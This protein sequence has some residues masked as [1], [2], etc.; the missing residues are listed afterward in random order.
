MLHCVF[1]ESRQGHFAGKDSDA[2]T[3]EDLVSFLSPGQ[4]LQSRKGE[5]EG[6]AFCSDRRDKAGAALYLLRTL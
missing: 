4:R 2:D 3:I 6:A 1:F 5:S